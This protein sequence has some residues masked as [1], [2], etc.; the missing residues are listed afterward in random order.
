MTEE[1][2]HHKIDRAKKV[3]KLLKKR[4]PNAKCSLNFKTVH[5]LMVATILSAQCTD[6]RVN[7]VTKLLFKKYKSVEDFANSDLQQLGRDIYATGFHNNKARSIKLSAQQLL[8]SHGGK[9][10]R[11]LD[12]LVKLSGVGRKTAS[13]ILGAGYGL[14]EGI[15]VDTHVARVSRL[16]GFTAEKDPLK[17]EK[18]LMKMI[19][20]KDWI[21]YAYL[22]IDHGRAI[23]QA[24]RP[25]CTNCFLNKLCP[26]AKV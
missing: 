12:E 21:A 1:A 3:I 13:V 17:I 26:S 11:R 5:Q 15:V 6:E 8:Q 24:R 9:I 7:Q 22:M 4:Y 2:L 16:L 23:C 10:P 19:P 14:A 20:K 18:D 25:D